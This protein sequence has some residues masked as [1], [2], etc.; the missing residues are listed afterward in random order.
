MVEAPLGDEERG[1]GVQVITNSPYPNRI[2]ILC[3][4]Y[5][6]PFV[7]AGP[8]G[9]FNPAR[10]LDIYVDGV[11]QIVQTFSFDQNNNRYLIYLSGSFNLQGVVQVVHHMPS[12]PFTAEVNPPIYDLTLGD[13]PGE[14]SGS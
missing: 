12:P 8:L 4:P 5:I 11:Q 9:L 2:Q 10:D 3:T 14:D 7:Q 13:E 6:G 1:S